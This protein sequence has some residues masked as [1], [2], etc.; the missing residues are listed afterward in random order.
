M[1][2]AGKGLVMANFIVADDESM[3]ARIRSVFSFQDPNAPRPEVLPPGQAAARLAREQAVGVVVAALPAD[4][5]TALDILG[6]IAPAAGGGL[7]AVGPTSD[8]RFVLQALRAGVRDYL[9]RA[10]LEVELAAALKRLAEPRAAASLGRVVAVLGAGGGAGAST[11]AANLAAALAAEHR[12]A[13][14]VDMKLETGDLAA[15]L[16][17]KPTFSLADL[18]R[19]AA[20]FDRVMLERTLARHESGVALLAAPARVA[21]AALVRAEGVARAIDLARAMFP[22]V[23]VDVDHTYREEQLAALRQADVLLLPFRLDFNSLRN[24]H[25]ALEHLNRMGLAGER[26]RLVVNR[27]GLP[28]E[29]PRA[30][31]EEALNMKIA[32]VVP[33]DFKAVARANNNGV[34]VV[35]EAPNSRAGRSLAQLARSLGPPRPSEAQMMH[36]ASR[37]GWRPWRR[38]VVPAA[39]R[40]AT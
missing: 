19:N 23:V 32:H 34:P 37:G 16:D 27:A 40:D 22:F 20:T 1:P 11:I 12:S 15:L 9:D 18:C 36:A 26:A 39:G 8:A 3:A 4:P 21:D 5:A 10:E 35:I 14:L 2:Q 7:L 13:G 29:V 17:L 38:H 28:V 24:V 33:E 30:K 6:R 25:R 31:A